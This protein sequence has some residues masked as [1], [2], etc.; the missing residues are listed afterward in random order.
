MRE[1]LLALFGALAIGGSVVAG[2]FNQPALAAPALHYDA[3][4]EYIVVGAEDDC[5]EGDTIDV[6]RVNGELRCYID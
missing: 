4:G 6:E 2:T 1:L 5:P 3:T